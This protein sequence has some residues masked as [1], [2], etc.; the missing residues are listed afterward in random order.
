MANSK[1][2]LQKLSK[3]KNT[4][5]TISS[6][7]LFS[8]LK[9]DQNENALVSHFPY[10]SVT[11]VSNARHESKKKVEKKGAHTHSRKIGEASNL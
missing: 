9:R 6:Q 4:P 5:T 11:K 10:S 1:G 7:L 8:F 2:K 3:G